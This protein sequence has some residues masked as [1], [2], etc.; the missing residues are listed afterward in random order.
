MAELKLGKE[1]LEQNIELVKERPT[2]ANL[3]KYSKY[4]K[5]SKTVNTFLETVER[6]TIQEIVWFIK[7][8]HL[9]IIS[10]VTLVI[11]C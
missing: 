2:A 4:L 9:E 8:T 6:T 7:T 1:F 10:I 3:I 11:A 5:L